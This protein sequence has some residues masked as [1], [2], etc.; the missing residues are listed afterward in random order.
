[1]VILHPA[2]ENVL[3]DARAMYP[4]ALIE[5]L[6]GPPPFA[7]TPRAYVVN[8]HPSD[9]AATRSL[10]LRYR[11]PDRRGDDAAAR[12]P[13]RVNQI[14][15]LL[16]AE[17]A[18][19]LP[20]VAEWTGALVVPAFGTYAIRLTTPASGHVDIDGARVLTSERRQPAE[21]RLAKGQ[22]TL[23]VVAEGAAGRI[24]LTWTPPDSTERDVPPAAFAPLTNFGGL[25]GT[26]YANA[27]WRGQPSLMAI[28]PVLDT[29]SISF[30][31][32]GPTP[33]S[34][35]GRSSPTRPASIAWRYVPLVMRGSRS[36]VKNC[37]PDRRTIR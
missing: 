37:L 28:D 13:N 17:H 9:L 10:E 33:L 18:P 20:F 26:Y 29:Y 12:S 34:G 35:A 23:K 15:A 2:D 31:W 16:P 5:T 27:E 21:L 14:Q 36:M 8:L 22:H 3:R 4:H 32:Q 19:T 1:M 6:T 30:H 11:T 7:A 25:L 24:R